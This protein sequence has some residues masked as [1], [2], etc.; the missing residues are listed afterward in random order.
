MGRSRR[1]T[2]PKHPNIPINFGVVSWKL[3]RRKQAFCVKSVCRKAVID[4]PSGSGMRV[5]QV[6]GGGR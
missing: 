5:G 3:T 6:A 2:E 4:D 1:F